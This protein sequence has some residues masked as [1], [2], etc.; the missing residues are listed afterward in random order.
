M[1]T[2]YEEM[3]S[4][5]RQLAGVDLREYSV[6]DGFS[7]LVLRARSALAM[8]DDEPVAVPVFIRKRIERAIES[9]INPK[10]MSV[11]DG[12]AR[13]H[14]SD[15]KHLL[16]VATTTK[17][18]SLIVPEG[19]TLYSA[20]FSLQASGKSENGRVML[21]RDND[22]R[23]EWYKL[24]DEDREQVALY[25]IGYGVTVNEATEDASQ[26]ASLAYPP[27][28]FVKTKQVEV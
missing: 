5:L 23:K 11:H 21:I 15:L 3:A 2:R 12:M 14:A 27:E 28:L 17:E 10:G 4:T 26:A 16:A 18:S 24:S 1:T 6:P 7:F 20:D 25:A 13:V 9:A 22:G 19:W 8:S